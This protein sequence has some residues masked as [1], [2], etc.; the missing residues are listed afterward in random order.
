MADVQHAQK[1]AGTQ[2][3]RAEQRRRVSAGMKSARARAY[4]HEHEAH[5]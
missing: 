1:Q 3:M 2:R 4:V 5:L